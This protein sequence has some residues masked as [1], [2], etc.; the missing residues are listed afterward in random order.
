MGYNDE[1]TVPSLP[2]PAKNT[3]LENKRVYA[4]YILEIFQHL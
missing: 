1:N 2:K 3:F 4:I